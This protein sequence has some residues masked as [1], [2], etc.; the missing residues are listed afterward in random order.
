MDSTEFINACNILQLNR[1]YTLDELKHAYR[2]LALKYHPDKC[3]DK[4]GNRF[5]EIHEAYSFLSN[6]D[7]KDVK[8]EDISYDSILQGF[9]RY[10][11]NTVDSKVL[12]EVIK[13]ITEKGHV[14][15]LEIL[16]N[17]DKETCVN[18]YELI[19]KY[20]DIFHINNSVL[21]ELD[22]IVR[23]KTKNDNIVI[24]NPTLEDLFHA[25][26]F[27]LEYDSA[28]FYVPLWHSELVY[29]LEDNNDLIV[30]C[31]PNIPNH[32]SID[33]FNNLHINLKHKTTLS[34]LLS[35]EKIV[36]NIV[37]NLDININ[38]KDLYIRKH[39]TIKFL[40]IGIPKISTND[41][42]YEGKKGNIF[43]HLEL[44]Y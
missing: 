14:Y 22:K 32:Y 38:I 12:L 15:S 21:C 5:R 27:A 19:M 33:E 2:K 7:A 4:S 11:N 8:D 41:M 40:N 23:E 31:I 26:C 39:Q 29:G 13:I 28:L 1:D 42:Y 35:K 25:N 17:C 34:N 43:I 9:V 37:E 36:Y 20:K 3:K 30:K 18:I 10:M 16:R 24:L 6:M 44:V